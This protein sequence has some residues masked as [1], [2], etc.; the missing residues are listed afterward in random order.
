LFP[1]HRIPIAMSFII[2]SIIGN[3]V[4]WK[5]KSSFSSLLGGLYIVS[6]PPTHPEPCPTT[7]PIPIL[8]ENRTD[9]NL[10]SQSATFYGAL[11]Q[12]FALI[13]AN[14]AGHTK[15]TIIN[16]IIVIVSNLGG[17]AGPFAYKGD[18]AAQN[19][20][21]GQISAI[22]LLVASLAAFILL[23]L[24]YRVQNK[25]KVAQAAANPELVND[26]NLAF[27]DLTDKQN[28]AFRYAM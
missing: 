27:L 2:P 7:L 4:L 26:P 25:R 13:A 21:T 9:N 10:P 17:F 18:E 15:K 1:R 22:V 12:A 3:I 6:P 11:I 14:T 28:P 24:Y 23:S 20:P 5:V 16:G 8:N 19:Y